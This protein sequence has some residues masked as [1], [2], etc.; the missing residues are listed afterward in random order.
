MFKNNLKKSL[1]FTAVA[2]TLGLGSTSAMAIAFPDFTVD[3]GSVPGSVANTFTADK[4]TGN[5][6]E[7]ITFN[8]LT[9]TTG[10]FDVALRW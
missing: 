2:A 10:S 5:Y 9:A 3:E 8:F 4:I 7:V 1:A 6:V